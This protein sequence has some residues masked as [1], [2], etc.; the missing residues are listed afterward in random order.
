[1][2]K[3]QTRTPTGSRPKRAKAKMPKASGGASSAKAEAAR[4]RLGVGGLAG[5]AADRTKAAGRGTFGPAASAP[6]A[7]FRPGDRPNPLIEGIRFNGLKAGKPVLCLPLRIETRF[8]NPEKPRLL[9]RIY[10]ERIFVDAHDPRLSKRETEIAQSMAKVVFKKEVSDAEKIN[11]WQECI[12]TVGPHRARYLAQRIS[13]KSLVAER[14]DEDSRP[15]YL[16]LLPKQWIVRGFVAGVKVFEA[17][18]EID[19]DALIA[20]SPEADFFNA[21]GVD[22]DSPIGWMTS[23][24]AAKKIGMAIEK[25]LPPAARNGFDQLIVVGEPTA[26]DAADALGTQLLAQLYSVGVGFAPQGMASNNTEETRSGWTPQDRD[27]ALHLAR[28][29]P[30]ALQ[31]PPSEPVSTGMLSKP[32]LFG[33]NRENGTVFE[34]ATGASVPRGIAHDTSSD[35]GMQRDMNNALWPVIWGRYFKTLMSGGGDDF[36]SRDDIAWIRDLCIGYMRGGAAIPA[37]RVGKSPYG[38]ALSRASSDV[39]ATE[40]ARRIVASDLIARLKPHWDEAAAQAESIFDGRSIRDPSGVLARLLERVA[41]PMRMVLRE[42]N[43]R[44]FSINFVFELRRRALFEGG[45]QSADRVND[46][47]EY[48]LGGSQAR[49]EY[50]PNINRQWSD[51]FLVYRMFIEYDHRLPEGS[52]STIPADDPRRLSNG[53]ILRANFPTSSDRVAVRGLLAPGQSYTDEEIFEVGRDIGELLGLCEDLFEDIIEHM[54]RTAIFETLGASEGL[55]KGTIGS[56][57]EDPKLAYTKYSAEVTEWDQAE[58]VEIDDQE[59]GKVSAQTWISYLRDLLRS[60]VT[61][62]PAPTPVF[63]AGQRRP[64]LYRLIHD[65]VFE[66]RQGLLDAGLD[67]GVAH[68]RPA[69][70]GKG[71]N[72]D[73]VL[74][75]ANAAT[76]ARADAYFMIDAL[77]RLAS[78]EADTLKLLMRQTLDLS[79]HRLDA[80]WQAFL[81]QDLE[82]YRETHANDLQIGAFGLVENLRPLWRDE[83]PIWNESFV[84]APSIQHAKTAAILRSGRQARSDKGD[85]DALS[86]DLSSQR[87]RK[88]QEA[89][90]GLRLGADLGDILGAMVERDL[91]QRGRQALIDPLRRAVASLTGEPSDLAEPLVDGLDLVSLWD[92]G[93]GKDAILD[94]MVYADGQAPSGKAGVTS[95]IR[96]AAGLADAMADLALAEATFDLVRGDSGLAGSTLAAIADGTAPVPDLQILKTPDH[97]PVV[98]TAVALTQHIEDPLW[99]KSGSLR[100]MLDL[101]TEKIVQAVLGP[102][103]DLRI[104]TE[105]GQETGLLDVIEQSDLPMGALDILSMAI[106]GEGGSPLERFIQHILG[107]RANRRRSTGLLKIEA[108]RKVILDARS[109]EAEDLLSIGMPAPKTPANTAGKR[110]K[111]YAKALQD[112]ADGLGKAIAVLEALL[113]TPTN[114]VPAPLAPEID[115]NALCA[116]IRKTAPFGA[117]NSLFVA[118][119]MEAAD[120]QNHAWR[121]LAELRRQSGAAGELLLSAPPAG[122]TGGELRSIGQQIFGREILVPTRIGGDLAAGVGASVQDTLARLAPVGRSPLGWLTDMGKTRPAMEALAEALQLDLALGA[123]MATPLVAQFPEKNGPRA[124]ISERLPE[125][126]RNAGSALFYAYGV[127]DIGELSAVIK[128]GLCGLVVD[129]ITER[130]PHKERDTALALELETPNAEAPQ[131]MAMILPHKDAPLQPDDIFDALARLF[132]WVRRRGVDGGDLATFE[133]HLPAAFT[134]SSVFES[135]MADYGAI[136]IQGEG[137]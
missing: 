108:W 115:P 98:T 75:Y 89:F 36:F 121:R 92:D 15:S 111:A 60:F 101:D 96:L 50:S 5:A 97:G 122:L 57:H 18:Q 64:L 80:L 70:K 135:A 45:H 6:G 114:E 44:E 1:M 3:R 37:L 43:D 93:Q 63:A 78:L 129:M 12:D 102:P 65:A 120:L 79:G 14:T 99:P 49:A 67:V 119:T 2:V 7:T 27:A 125:T 81:L 54:D 26:G 33:A 71:R 68:G 117:W 28:S 116:A 38:I 72:R 32:G 90:E 39:A 76:R 66:R 24:A 51:V 86:V 16:R 47:V 61:E 23:F 73:A 124:W 91:A 29:F 21:Q 110:R 88:A 10:P 104:V 4:K 77:R 137:A 62:E 123:D 42:L 56:A 82:A 52:M 118:P 41:H 11:I 40:D 19:Q 9:L 13:D 83:A 127:Q 55:L 95:S 113:P 30:E 8:A 17:E 106:G 20:A 58:L 34:N 132:E 85:T 128:A 100:S 136:A 112:T 133:A 53:R 31:S 126:N 107:E 59:Y 94:A 87:M 84:H 69:R 46:I 48:R 130:V 25:P 22:K 134:T 103:E 131:V 105:S 35:D 109:L 74:G